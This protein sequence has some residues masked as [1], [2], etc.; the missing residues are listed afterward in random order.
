MALYRWQ[1]QPGFSE[2][3]HEF[4]EVENDDLPFD[5]PEDDTQECPFCG[6]LDVELTR[7]SHRWTYFICC[8]CRSEF[9]L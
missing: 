1:D 5:E 9:R 4:L 2:T 8:D 3:E 7:T 6:S